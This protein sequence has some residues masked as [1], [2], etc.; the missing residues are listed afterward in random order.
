MAHEHIFFDL[1]AYFTP[2][3]DDPDGAHAQAPISV[4]ELWWLRGHPMNNPE[5]LRQ[6]DHEL[7]VREV[8]AFA[9]AGGGTIVDVTTV[10]LAPDPQ[11]LV[12]VSRRTGVHIVAGTG[13]YIDSSLPGWVAEQPVEALTDFLRRELLEGIAGTTVRAGLIGELGVAD[14]P[15]PAEERV[16]RAAAMVQRET[17]CAVTLHPYWGVDAALAAARY[18]EAAGVDPMRTSICHLDNRFRADVAHYREV[19]RRGYFLNLDCF[20]RDL[21]YPQYRTQL[22]AD[23]ERIRAVAALLDAGLEDRLLFS[24]DLCFKHELVA[25]GGYGYAHVLRTIRPRMVDAGIQP[26]SIEGILVGNPRRWLAGE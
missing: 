11:G 12:E 14:P 4:E 22:P 1:S 18:G 2:A 21:Y 8:G 5:N 15:S 20:G 25:Y 16:L 13:F 19:A 23:S 3:P 6:R 7:A 10:G 26:D 9:G 17:G 24:Q